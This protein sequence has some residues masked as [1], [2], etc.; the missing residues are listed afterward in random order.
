VT[1]T[2]LNFVIKSGYRI[3]DKVAGRCPECGLRRQVHV[4]GCTR[5]FS[6]NPQKNG[7]NSA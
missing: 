4:P 1:S 6:R 3:W 7:T 2:I 5:I